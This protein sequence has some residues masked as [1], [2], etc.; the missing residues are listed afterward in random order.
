MSKNEIYLLIFGMAAVT[1]LPRALPALFMR[2]LTLG[3]K[4]QRFLNLLP[5]TAMAALIFPGIFCIDGAHP[6]YGAA[7][8]LAATLLAAKK[9]P[10][11][12]SVLAAVAV[13]SALYFIT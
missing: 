1:Y 13:C 5:Y 4:T 10:L 7:G 8:A 11:I 3:E 6:L 9:C 2:K 12:V